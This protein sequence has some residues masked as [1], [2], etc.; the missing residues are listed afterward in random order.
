[1]N[2]KVPVLLTLL[3]ASLHSEVGGMY[4]VL[5]ELCMCTKFSSFASVQIRRE[6]RVTNNILKYHGVVINFTLMCSKDVIQVHACF[7]TF[8]VVQ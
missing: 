6:H 3:L 1:M 7:G 2:A 4:K 5:F 8:S